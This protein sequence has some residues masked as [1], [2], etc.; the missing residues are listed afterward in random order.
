MDEAPDF[1]RPRSDS[2]KN[3]AAHSFNQLQETSHHDLKPTFMKQTKLIL[4]AALICTPVISRAV[5]V[6]NSLPYT[7]TTPGSYV[8][9]SSLTVN[10]TDGIDVKASNVSINL[11]G[12]TLTQAQIGAGSGIRAYPGMSNVSIQN[13]S[14]IGFGTGVEFN[15]GSDYVL[16]NVRLFDMPGSAV[17]ISG[18]DG[19]LVENCFIVGIGGHSAIYQAISISDCTGAILIKNNQISEFGIGIF[20][21]YAHTPIALIGNYEANCTAGLYLSFDGKYQGNITTNCAL[22]V[23]SG[24]AVGK[25]NG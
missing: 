8:L 24:T 13:G 6:I 9:G 11:G 16:K 19:C 3:Q 23:V 12:Y 22:P 20:G 7:I 18:A 4:L 15:P 10:G 17:T 1:T 5:T 2:Q 25:E 14:I 21:I